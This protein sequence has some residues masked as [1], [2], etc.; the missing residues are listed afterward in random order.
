MKNFF[1]LCSFLFLT[2]LSYGQT[3]TLVVTNMTGVDIQAGAET[4]IQNYAVCPP[5]ISGSAN[6]FVPNGG[7]VNIILGTVAAGAPPIRPYR[8]GAACFTGGPCSV[9][10]QINT[11][12]ALTCITNFGPYNITIT[13][14]SD[15]ETHVT[16][17]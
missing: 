8:I 1:L 16:I 4:T 14:C 11:C 3:C 9:N 6:D 12:W 2:N 7:T 17:G 10:W 5:L 15:Y 13:F